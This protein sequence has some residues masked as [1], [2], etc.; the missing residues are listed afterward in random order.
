MKA[1]LFYLFV[2]FICIPLSACSDQPDSPQLTLTSVDGTIIE[3]DDQSPLTALFFFSVSNPVAL[4]ALYRL[5]DELD[6]AADSIAIAM[7]VNRPPNI[8]ITQQ[9]TLVPIVIDEADRI[10]EAF[11]SIELTPALILVRKGRI[12]VK[13]QGRLDFE[14]INRV[15]H[16]QE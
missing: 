9:R 12:L 13:Q 8:T 10:S 1:I 11:G 2:I 3:L 5:S 4:G 15:I 6:D 7:H 14:V 16:D